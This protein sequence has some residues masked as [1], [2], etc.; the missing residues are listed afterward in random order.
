V[1]LFTRL[2]QAA[3]PPPAPP[4]PRAVWVAARQAHKGGEQGRDCQDA[5]AVGVDP[6]RAAVADGA[7]KTFFAREWAWL[8]VKDF[9]TGPSADPGGDGAAWVAPLREQWRAQVQDLIAQ[10][11]SRALLENRLH[12]HDPASATFASL[13][14]LPEEAAWCVRAIGDTCLLRFG[15]DG[16]FRDSFPL[17][18]PGAFD[19]HPQALVSGKATNPPALA[20]TRLPALPD[21]VLVLATDALAKWLLS[22][23]PEAR[24]PAVARLLEGGE[25]AFDREVEALRRGRDGPEM[26][27]DDVTIVAVSWGRQRPG[28]VAIEALAAAAPPR[29]APEALPPEPAPSS[30]P[31]GD[32]PPRLPAMS[33]EGASF[34]GFSP[35]GTARPGEV[36]F[37][38]PPPPLPPV[39]AS[40]DAP[41]PPPVDA[42]GPGEGA[43]P[44]VPAEPSEPAE[45]PESA[46]PP[47]PSE[48][49]GPPEPAPAARGEA[50]EVPAPDAGPPVVNGA[51]RVAPLLSRMPPPVVGLL[52]WLGAW[53]TALAAASGWTVALAL[54]LTGGW[55]RP[56]PA[57]QAPAAAAP[58]PAREPAASAPGTAAALAQRVLVLPGELPVGRADGAPPSRLTHPVEGRVRGEAD[59][60]SVV[61]V[62]AWISGTI[63]GQTLS[64][65]EGPGVL[66]VGTRVQLRTR[67]SP[68]AEA[69]TGVIGE[70]TRGARFPLDPT[71][72]PIGDEWYPISIEIPLPTPSPTT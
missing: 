30:D 1:N 25:E 31:A 42:A 64:R 35:A 53:S 56:A 58:A 4:P 3:A 54:L 34:L 2:A 72:E 66:A 10:S 55:T 50:D 14:L 69:D 23:A 7:T 29:Y 52:A 61:A 11:P 8:L 70:A 32:P 19:N 37:R 26:E 27:D 38:T 44:A 20:E 18:H 22:L 6:C 49:S 51:P 39:P 24:F 46:E 62:A 33:Q 71:H 47:E 12:R 67:P 17:D 43:E 5:W 41:P 28:W 57:G 63:G 45:P 36:A 59:G 68:D 13:E 16:G 60:T 9:C 48:P 65:R 21:E 40:P 15:G